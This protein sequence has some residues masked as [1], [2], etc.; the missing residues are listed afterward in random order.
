MRIVELVIENDADG[1]DA[2]SV[3]DLPAIESNFIALATDFEVKLAE[4]DAEKRI[5]MGAALIPNKQIFRRIGDD[6]F[7]VYFSKETVKQASE[8]F[9]KNG[10]QSNAT[11]Q[12][13]A[14]IDGMTVVESW[15]VDDLEF[16]KSKKYG[17]SV[18]V[19]TWMISMKVDNEDI[20]QRVKAGEIKGFSIEG[21]FA[22]KL[23]M[24][25]EQELIDQIIKILKDA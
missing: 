19:G 9:L 11:L 4:V 23:E 20:W 16:D 2:V 14:K 24:Q 17:F 13:D 12:H 7:Y 21:Y 3:V 1:I 8:L 22:D 18:P 6:E 25:K 5:L 10:N 15:I